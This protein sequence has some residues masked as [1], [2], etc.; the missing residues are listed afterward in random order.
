MM[1]RN[2]ALNA[3][4]KYG[5]QH[6]ANLRESMRRHKETRDRLAK[7]E[8]DKSKDPENA[9]IDDDVIADLIAQA[10]GNKTDL[11]ERTDVNS[12]SET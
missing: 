10:Q 7:W 5:P 1:R 9:S 2:G 8:A 3:L 6:L 11:E 12:S 4:G